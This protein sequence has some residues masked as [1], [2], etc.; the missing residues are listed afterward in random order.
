MSFFSDEPIVYPFP[1]IN[2]S[3]VYNYMLNP[4][5]LSRNSSNTWVGLGTP[6][7]VTMYYFLMSCWIVFANIDTGYQFNSH[8]SSFSFMPTTLD[9][10]ADSNFFHLSRDP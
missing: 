4:A 6:E 10:L 5:S 2:P 1:A 7:T 8:L 3:C 9:I